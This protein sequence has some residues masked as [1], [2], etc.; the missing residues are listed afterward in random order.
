MQFGELAMVPA[1]KP[2]IGR[3]DA[4]MAKVGW[5]DNFPKMVKRAGPL[6]TMT[7]ERTSSGASTAIPVSCS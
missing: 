6:F 4:Y 2:L 1:K 7:S 3:V 5:G